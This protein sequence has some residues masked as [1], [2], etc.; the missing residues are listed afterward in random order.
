MPR[1]GIRRG[2][3]LRWCVMNNDNELSLNEGGSDCQV[4]LENPHKSEPLNLSLC[5]ACPGGRACTHCQAG[6]YDVERKGRARARVL[7][8]L[9]DGTSRIERGRKARRR[10]YVRCSMGLEIAMARGH[11]V[12]VFTLSESDYAIGMGLNFGK[13]VNKFFV[14][15]QYDYGCVIPR[16]VIT[17]VGKS[18]VRLDRHIVCYGTGKLDVLAMDAHWHKVY[19]SKLTGMA[20]VWSPRGLSFYLSKYLGNSEEK[21]VE[22]RMS[23]AW[24]FPGWWKFNLAYHQAYGVYPPVSVFVWLLELPEEERRREVDEYMRVWSL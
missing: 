6:R 3:V 14:K 23:P 19:G 4:I 24:V 15:M 7:V 17:H 9:S 10:F 12:R 21:F 5:S 18:G 20:Q 1:Q 22:G 16:Y 11:V 13:A 2:T 8:T